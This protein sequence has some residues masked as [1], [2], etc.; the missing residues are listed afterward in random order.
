MFW[1]L[2]LMF[3]R[4]GLFIGA[5]ILLGV[6][7]NTAAPHFPQVEPNSIVGLH[8]WLQYIISVMSWPLGLWHPT[9]TLGKWT[10]GAR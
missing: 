4:F 6:F 7:L 8:A 9:F 10:A 2:R 1:N 3:S 5:Y